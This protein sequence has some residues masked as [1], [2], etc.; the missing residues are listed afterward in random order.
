MKA[1]M[2]LYSVVAIVSSTTKR[3]VTSMI[4][5]RQKFEGHTKWVWGVIH[6]PVGITCSGDGSLRALNLKNGKQIGEDWREVKSGVNGIALS[7][8][9]MKL[10]SGSDDGVVRL[11]DIDT[12]KVIKKWTGHTRIVKSVCSS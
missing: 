11:W 4:T 7:P 8:D 5:P 9:G 6:L 10:V 2:A 1:E 3:K 12:C